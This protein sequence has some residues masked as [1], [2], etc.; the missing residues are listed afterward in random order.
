[1]IDPEAIYKYLRPF[2]DFTLDGE[3]WGDEGEVPEPYDMPIDD[4]YQTAYDAVTAIRNVVNYIASKGGT[5]LL[6]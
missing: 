2:A 4:A 1:M 6:D 3:E 5:A